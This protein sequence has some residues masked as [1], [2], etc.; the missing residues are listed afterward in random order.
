LVE[1]PHRVIQAKFLRPSLEGAVTRRLRE[2]RA[3]AQQ[4]K[5]RKRIAGQTEMLLPIAGKKGNEV[6]AARPGDRRRRARLRPA[7]TSLTYAIE[8]RLRIQ[9]VVHVFADHIFR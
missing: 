9:P 6:A 1:Q 5:G 3:S 2:K 7:Q 8:L 4:K